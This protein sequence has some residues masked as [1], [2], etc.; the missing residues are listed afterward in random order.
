MCKILTQYWDEQDA[1]QAQLAA[2]RLNPRL[3]NW[4]YSLQADRP[5]IHARFR[6]GKL[7]IAPAKSMWE[8]PASWLPTDNSLGALRKAC[9]SAKINLFVHGGSSG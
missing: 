7:Q 9:C 1:F 2:L 4:L 3:R 6:K 5:F 8:Q